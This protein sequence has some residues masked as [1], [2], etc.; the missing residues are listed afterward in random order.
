MT[1]GFAI[2]GCGMIS[3]FHAKAIADLR[4]AEIVAAIELVDFRNA[5]LF[6]GVTPRVQDVP[7]HAALLDAQIAAAAVKLVRAVLR[8]FLG[9]LRFFR[10]NTLSLVGGVDSSV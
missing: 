3:R 7:V 8:V 6:R 9:G 5:A 10:H 2:V 1:T 4:G